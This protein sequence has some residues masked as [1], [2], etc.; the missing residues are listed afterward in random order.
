MES[1]R[2]SFAQANVGLVSPGPSLPLV[3]T[4]EGCESR[5]AGRQ[6]RR[7]GGGEG[8]QGVDPQ[9]LPQPSPVP[10][11]PGFSFSSVLLTVDR[12][13]RAPG[14]QTRTGLPE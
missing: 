3:W 6:A 5:V 4:Q 7:E 2:K 11:P 1:I 10:R 13:L 12:L 8:G 14:G 9:P